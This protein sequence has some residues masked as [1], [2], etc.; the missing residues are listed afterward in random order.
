MDHDAVPQKR[1]LNTFSILACAFCLIAFLTIHSNL[2]VSLLLYVL[3]VVF[4]VVALIQIKKT[5]QIGKTVSW[6]VLVFSA[7]ALFLFPALYFLE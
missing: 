1:K 3:A 5:S 6:I 2:F 4:S 7:A